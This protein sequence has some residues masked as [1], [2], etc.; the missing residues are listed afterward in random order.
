MLFAVA[1]SGLT[2]T[3][4]S[5]DDL[6]TN[7]YGKNGVNILAFGPMPITRGETMR[8]TGTKLDQVKEVLF[9]E[10]NQKLTA[11]TTY[12][13][14]QFTLANSQE[15]TVT[16]PDLCVPGKLR[17]VTNSNDTI[18]STSNITFVEEIKAQ[19]IS[20]LTVHPG[21]IVT[22][23][24]E[25]VWNIAEVTFSA[26][27]K[28]TAEAFAKNTRNEVQIYVPAAAV[29]GPVTYNDGSEGAEEKVLTDNLVV[30]YAVATG[31]SNATP[32]YGEEITITGENLDLVYI[33]SFP[34]F[35]EVR[36]FTCAPDGKSIKVVVP[37]TS[38]SGNVVL[39][40]YSGL[41]TSVEI[42]VP[43]ISYEAGSITPTE[44][45]KAGDK[46]TLKGTLLD[47]VQVVRL[48][49]DI[50]LQKGEFEQSANEISFIVPK[51][52][53]DGKVVLVQHD[54]YSVETDKIAMHHDGAEKVIWSGNCEVDW[55]VGAALDALSWGK[56][57]WSDLKAGDEIIVYVDFVDPSAG[58]A[59]ISPRMGESWGELSVKQ[60]DFTPSAETQRT[61]FKV[62]ES[63]VENIKNKGG[64]IITGFGCI[65]KQ[66][67][68]PIPQ[69]IAW[70]GNFEVDWNVGAGL[71]ALA[72]GQY[73]WSTFQ[74]G[75][76]IIITVGFVD[77]SAGW[78]C[79]S[80]RMGESWGELSVKQIDFTPSAEDQ[81]T[82]FIPTA[83]DIKHLQ[84]DKGLVVTGFGCIV[85][86]IV[87][88]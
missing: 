40:S 29:T 5:E 30:D 6:S 38:T 46:V 43:L 82:T 37:G 83:D 48:P 32:E 88:Q 24:G 17:L 39:T 53:G 50:L 16:I 44:E 77:P 1:L 18:V 26:G 76:K 64:L 33:V 73:D 21:D 41:T 25:Y 13:Q 68:R 87:I 54:N 19:S 49:G 14:G 20:P 60:I 35:G 10:G 65:V 27:V 51:G 71:D 85:K 86:Q 72:W 9:P 78:A 47:R 8:L 23:K 61:S 58:W 74:A 3:A 22:I 79:I 56:Y 63:D 15:M 70:S 81:T 45:L 2:L 28:V 52:M 75:Q 69:I 66:V 36:E 12:I 31:V 59:C 84:N 57:D 55:N 42:A 67:A 7:Q 4:C 34:S 80:P 62:T 11:A